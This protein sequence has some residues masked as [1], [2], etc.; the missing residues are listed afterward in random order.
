MAANRQSVELGPFLY[1]PNACSYLASEQSAYNVR[2]LPQMS[3]ERYQELLSRGWRRF[4]WRLFRQKCPTC[5]QCRGLRLNVAQF[6]PNRSQ[7]R[8][9]R[10]NAG[11]R[12]VI[13]PP[14]LT[15]R[16]LEMYNAFHADMQIRRGWEGEGIDAAG[17]GESFL[18]GGGDW[19]REFLYYAGEE[20]VGVGLA[21]V[22]PAALSSV[23]FYHD[24]RYR[25][26]GLGVFSVLTQWA[27][28]QTHGLRHQYLGYWIAACPSMAYKSQYEPHELLAGAPS[29]AEEPAWY[30]PV[31][32]S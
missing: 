16:H 20:L 22:V 13:Q 7:R 27:Y 18:K 21:D 9:L 5:T 17:Y 29:D 2:L 11:L 12:V 23:Y 19:A 8:N 24:P 6:R 15:E 4:G 1:G 31:A 26:R 10:D 30:S 14:T 28:C 3:A 32:R 25:S